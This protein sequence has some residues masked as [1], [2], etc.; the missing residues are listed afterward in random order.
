MDALTA[1]KKAVSFIRAYFR[2]SGRKMAVLGLSGG[3]DSAVALALCVRALGAKNT[4]AA[5]LPSDSTPKADLRDALGLAK[6][7]NVR[8]IKSNIEPALYAFGW[9]SENTMGRANL[10]ARVRMA[11]LYSL[12]HKYNGLVVGT[13]NKSEL[14]LGYFTKHGDGAADLFPLAGLYKTEVKR[15]GAHLRLPKRMLGKP[16]SPALWGGQTAEKE[17]GFSYEEADGILMGL[18][19]RTPVA[20]LCRKFSKKTVQS[21][22]RLMR[23]N[24]H[25]LFPAPICKMPGI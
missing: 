2:K 25:K 16:P 15:L 19:K 6:R 24:R 20:A 10:S 22:L 14:L 3:L 5:I 18:E 4:I 11:V 17:L 21:V 23:Q 8:V 1:E 12:A 13:G 7:L 9:L